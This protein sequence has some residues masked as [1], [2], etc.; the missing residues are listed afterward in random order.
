MHLCPAISHRCCAFTQ[1]EVGEFFVD[2]TIGGQGSHYKYPRRDIDY[3]VQSAAKTLA[4][5]GR[6]GRKNERWVVE[7]LKANPVEG[8]N[9]AVFGSMEPWYEAML[10]CT[11]QWL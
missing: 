10:V 6:G 11:L 1:L 5:G 2:D 7:A 3:M 8:L 9:V 4:S